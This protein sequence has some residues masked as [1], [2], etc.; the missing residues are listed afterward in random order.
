VGKDETA[1]RKK[2]EAPTVTLATAEK[3]SPKVRSEVAR[4]L[5]ELTSEGPSFPKSNGGLWIELSLEGKFKNVSEE[6]CVLVGYSR[7]ELLGRR[8]DE[9]TMP[10]GLHFPSILARSFSS[11]AFI[12]SGCSRAT[13]A[14]WFWF[15]RIGNFFRTYRLRCIAR[16]FA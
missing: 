2:Y 7:N 8:I 15:V 12:V 11:G 14:V 10:R 4:M 9:I 3:L 5:S 16:R 1:G 13:T 6:F